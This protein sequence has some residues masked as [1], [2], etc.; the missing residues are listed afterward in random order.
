MKKHNIGLALGLLLSL[1]LIGLN[2]TFAQEE[3]VTE[4]AGSLEESNRETMAAPETQWLW[5]EVVSV[6]LENNEL[7]V[8]HLDYDTYTEKE[9]VITVDGDTTYE[10]I[11]SILEIKPQDT[12]SLDYIINPEGK[13]VAKNISVEKLESAEPE[14]EGESTLGVSETHPQTENPQT[15]TPSEE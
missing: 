9:V 8:K 1:T 11:E 5:G 4:E 12:V 10:N 2:L 6:D 14:A 13:N 15:E 7:L 3:A